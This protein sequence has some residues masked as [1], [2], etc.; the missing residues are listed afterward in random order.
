MQTIK[1]SHIAKM[2]GHAGFLAL[3]SKGEIEKAKICVREGAR[4]IEGIVLGR[5][6]WEVP[7]I[8]SRICG[9]CPTVHVLC[10]ISAIE[11]ALDVKVS[12][13]VKLLRKLM[14]CGEIIHSH[15]LHLFFLSLPDFFDLSNDLKLIKKYPKETKQALF[16]RD[17]GTK[18]VEAVGGRT[19]HPMNPK[20]GG[21]RTSVKKEKLQNILER[22]DEALEAAVSLAE[23]FKK[24]DYPQFNRKTNFVSL[25]GDEYAFHEGEVLFSGIKKKQ[26]LTAD[27]FYKKVRE[28]QKS[29]EVVKRTKFGKDYY[30]LGALARINNHCLALNKEAQKLWKGFFDRPDFNIFHNIFAQAVEVVHFIEEARKITE[31]VI[32]KDLDNIDKEYKIKGGRGVWALEAPRGVLFHYY[33]IDKTGEIVNC[34]IITPSAQFL[35]NLEEDLRVFVPEIFKKYC[36]EDCRK[37]IRTLI[38]A[39]DPCISCATH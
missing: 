16:V 27:G 34:N 30:L 20:I 26:T 36:R 35:A 10:A 11:K 23:L 2:E 25:S 38:R 5:K 15:S 33:E 37:K 31:E 14:H 8:I 17:F 24:L 7:I 6:I 1:I 29:G 21:F 32:K 39:Y 19:I 13:E 22:C 9:I 12:R 4:L 28:I 3:M 18:I